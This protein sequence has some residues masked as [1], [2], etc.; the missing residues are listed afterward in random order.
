MKESRR[1]DPRVRQMQNLQR[2]AVA[3]TV[4]AVNEAHRRGELV[5]LRGERPLPDH[6]KGKVSSVS[7]RRGFQV[8]AR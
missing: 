3:R 8:L 2:D 1:I 5:V 6:G 4:V 7:G